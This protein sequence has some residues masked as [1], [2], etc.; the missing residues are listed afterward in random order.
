MTILQRLFAPFKMT[1]REYE[2]SVTALNI[3][4]G[5]VIG[6]SLG[7]IGEM[8][9]SEYVTTLIFTSSSVMAVL[10]VAY[11]ERKL[12]NLV[13]T[14]MVLGAVWWADQSPKEV[15]SLPPKVMPTLAVWLV[16][17][18]FIEVFKAFA[19]FE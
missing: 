11:S 7:N 18:L 8:P 17:V 9:T 5:A 3:F 12:M 1:A 13:I 14:P 6:V 10:F 19:D 15:L 2:A 16:L 4:F